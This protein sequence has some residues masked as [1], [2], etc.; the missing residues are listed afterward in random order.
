MRYKKVDIDDPNS[1]EASFTK[2]DIIK[3]LIVAAVTIPTAAVIGLTL[4]SLKDVEKVTAENLDAKT[5]Q[6]TTVN[7]SDGSKISNPSNANKKMPVKYEEI[8]KCMKDAIVAIE[9]ERYYKH[10]GVD[11]KGLVRSAVKTLLGKNQ[12][13]STITMQT[14]KML[15]T[16][17]DVSIPRK[18]KD[19]YYAYKMNHLLGKEK[20]LE[21]YLNN[22]PV[23]RGLQG[24]KAG[25]SGY[26]NKD[27]DELTLPEAA[28]L[29]GSTKNPSKFSAYVTEPLSCNE[30]KEDLDHKL[31]FYTNTTKDSFEDPKPNEIK[32]VDQLKEWGLIPDADTY[33]QLKNG[34]MVVRKATLNKDAKERQETVLDKMC[35]VGYLN[36]S[37]LQKYKDTPINIQLPDYEIKVSSSIEDYVEEEAINTLV[38]AGYT[39]DDALN[40]YFN[41]GLTVTTSVD[42]LMQN[43][44]ENIYS[45][46][47]NFPKHIVGEDGIVQPQSASVL[48]DNK[49]SHIKAMIGG[50][51]IVGRKVLNRA[52]SPVQPGSAIKPLAVYTPAIIGKRLNESSV[53]SDAEGGYRFEK[54][55]IWNPHTTTGGHSTFDLRTA[56]AKSSNTIAVKIG[57]TLGDT[58]DECVDIMISQ[59]KHY[60][61]TSIIDSKDG[62]NDREF[63]SLT[64]GGMAKG[65]S[66]LDMAS[67]YASIANKGVYTEPKIITKIEAYNGKVLYDDKLNQ[68]KV[69]TEEEAYVMTDM[70]HAV[71]VEGTGKSAKFSNLPVAGKTGTTNDDLEAWFVGFT[72]YYTCA[73][74]IADDAGRIDKLGNR[75]QRRGVG[76]GSASSAKLWSKIMTDVHKGLPFKEF[77]KPDK[78]KLIEN[79]FYIPGTYAGI[80]SK[81]NFDEK[82]LTND[83]IDKLEESNKVDLEEMKR[84]PKP[85]KKVSNDVTQ[86]LPYDGGQTNDVFGIPFIPSFGN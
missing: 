86:L 64:L 24:V 32:F 39:K 60:G 76:G 11:I 79:R 38:T 78:V 31:L 26:F 47:A 84:N 49:N 7:Y 27:L 33:Q 4:M 37:E 36:Q 12:G 21:L 3:K 18:I 85:D 45:N 10:P 57:E 28:M 29:A 54:N 42:K 74:Y 65:I 53:F 15:M 6:I 2:G 14:S 67:A 48:I 19:I 35:E 41:G 73:T 77:P 5:Y 20:V 13:G 46:P 80:D 43:N 34:T 66:P 68:H 72:P 8:P 56:L 59:L 61:I 23:G 71:T 9:D 75:I 51:N 81:H 16:S 52:T 62:Q 25:A 40:M 50:R 22:F 63:S 82:Y 69:L 58:Y 83:E 17:A 1:Y 44:L 30:S 55:K 70:L